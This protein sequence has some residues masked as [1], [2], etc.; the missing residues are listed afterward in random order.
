VGRIIGIDLGTTNSAAA[1]ADGNELRMIPNDRGSNLTPSIVSVADNGDVL[2]GA[3]AKNQAIIHA[4][5]TMLHVKRHMG[6]DAIITLGERGYSPEE[7]SAFILSKLRRDA[8]TY[9]GTDVTEAVVTVPAHFSEKQRQAT[10]EAG[11]LAGLKIR[12]IINEP[13]AAAL[14]YAYR[15][16]G[17]QKILVYDLG[18]GTFDVTC[19]LKEGKNF[20]VKST[21][22][23]N[24]LGG[25]D[26]D[27]LLRDKVIDKFEAESGID[28]R[29]DPILMQQLSEVTE[30]AKIELS[31]RDSALIAMPFISSGG[32]PVHLSYTI[33]RREFDALIEPLLKETVKLTLNAV[34]EA[35]FG[36]SGIDSLVLSGGS[37]RIPLVR[38]FLKR[39]LGL[40]E[41]AMVNPDEIVATGAALQGQLLLAEGKVPELHDVTGYTLGVE[42]EGNQFVPLIARNT[43]LPATVQKVFT[44]V[45]DNQSSVEINVLQGESQNASE[46]E[47][48][49]RFLLSGIAEDARGL[50]RIEVTFSVDRDG[51]AHV[52][53]QDTQTGVQQRITVAPSDLTSEGGENGNALIVRVASLLQRV[54]ELTPR[55]EEYVDADFRSE[56]TQ[57]A[58]MAKKAIETK[59]MKELTEARLALETVLGELAALFQEMEAG[60]EGA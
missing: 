8:E 10:L 35:E 39:A 14:A 12:R 5:R 48:L 24:S 55:A 57:M 3:S 36:I 60:S 25:I 56:I 13:T 15:W 40:D 6:S 18:G 43:Q 31:S 9:I 28:F 59:R 21:F 4:E 34:K 22:G 45:S 37:S 7:V 20:T 19:L 47:S 41:V 30:R 33:T 29:S 42:I 27:N 11:R 32:K 17:S 52:S 16:E 58:G 54:R 49:G 50:P 51:I 46:N 2:V 26:F 23:N 1:F 44:T 53:A 38:T